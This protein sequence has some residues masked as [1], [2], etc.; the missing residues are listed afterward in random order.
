MSSVANFSRSAE[1]R[2]EIPLGAAYRAD[3]D[4]LARVAMQSTRQAT[5]ILEKPAP[6]IIFWALGT[7]MIQ[8]TAYLRI[9]MR[10]AGTTEAHDAGVRMLKS[11]FEEA[12]IGAPFL[13]PAA[14][15][16]IGGSTTESDSTP[17]FHFESRQAP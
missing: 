12:A 2:I 17:H 14:W 5:G 8:F 13:H 7:T 4:K 10:R 16:P 3:L 6:P 1:K 9:D 11:A 15:Q